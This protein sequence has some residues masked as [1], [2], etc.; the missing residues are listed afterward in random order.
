M[1]R[2]TST[3]SPFHSTSE[4][5]LV[6]DRTVEPQTLAERASF[7]SLALSCFE[8][9]IKCESVQRRYCTEDFEHIGSFAEN[10]SAPVS[11][12]QFGC[13]FEQF[14]VQRRLKGVSVENRDVRGPS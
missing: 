13:F 12:T 14:V 10:V 11:I 2:D 6:Y 1:R 4:S 5:Q 7:S 3:P 9:I 8:Y